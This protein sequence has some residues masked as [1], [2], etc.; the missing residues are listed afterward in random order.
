M[1]DD[2]DDLD[3]LLDKPI[4]LDE[5]APTPE[6]DL[7]ELVLKAKAKKDEASRRALNAMLGEE[8]PT[9][10]DPGTFAGMSVIERS[11]MS[12][13]TPQ[14]SSL[15]R[16]R[17]S[18]VPLSRFIRK[19]VDATVKELLDAVEHEH[20]PANPLDWLTDTS[21][22]ALV[23]QLQATVKDLQGGEVALI[24]LP[25]RP[26]SS[27]PVPQATKIALHLDATPVDGIVFI[28]T[29]ESMIKL[30]TGLLKHGLQEGRDYEFVTQENLT[31]AEKKVLRELTNSRRATLNII[32]KLS[33]KQAKFSTSRS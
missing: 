12:F 19:D 8:P 17:Q 5:E 18:A 25:K 3:A 15:V 23:S 2:L 22:A 30:T 4:V 31:G 33:L 10:E 11:H 24:M 1:A 20:N 16:L 27:K 9:P 21:R 26:A 29:T 7:D 13:I 32:R 14:A 6:P 28:H